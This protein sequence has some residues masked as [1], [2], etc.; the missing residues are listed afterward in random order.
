MHI[1]IDTVSLNGEPFDM[2]VVQNDRVTAGQAI[3][4]FDRTAIANAGL[5]AQTMVIVTNAAGHAQQ[6]LVAQGVVQAG[7]R[8]IGF[9][10]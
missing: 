3:G 7:D 4:S 6:N 10:A 5:S 2:K 9:S 8:L 1:G